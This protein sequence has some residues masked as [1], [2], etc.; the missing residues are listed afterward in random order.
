MKNSELY[1]VWEIPKEVEGYHHIVFGPEIADKLGWVYGL[2]KKGEPVP[3]G[4]TELFALSDK[5]KIQDHQDID[6][7]HYIFMKEA[8]QPLN[9]SQILEIRKEAG[10][11]YRSIGTAIAAIV[12]MISGLFSWAVSE[13]LSSVR[14]KEL[15]SLHSSNLKEQVDRYE[16]LLET[17]ENRFQ[18]VLETQQS[19][20]AE[21]LEDKNRSV[22]EA[23]KLFRSFEEQLIDQVVTANNLAA[24]ASSHAASAVKQ[25]DEATIKSAS[26]IK[27][28]ND[29]IE[30]VTATN[31][32]FFLTKSEAESLINKLELELK[33]AKLNSSDQN[34][35]LSNAEEFIKTSVSNAVTN[36]KIGVWKEVSSKIKKFTLECEYK[37]V[38]PS[39][40]YYP[41]AIEEHVLTFFIHN[42]FY[43]L[44]KDDTN[45]FKKYLN[46]FGRDEIERSLK[47]RTFERC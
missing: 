22:E 27:S 17:Q 47:V 32:E 20:Y 14:T 29:L 12:A 13:H 15:V 24:S 16:K 19:S 11:T 1:T 30:K 5:N 18:R 36:I 40:I 3:S 42:G 23:L 38:T 6:W 28:I 26:A 44:E 31:D 33:K 46:F 41:G 39:V 9:D 4:S 35:A 37:V 7:L 2:V 34:G 43:G 8:T 21:A 45:S 25:S 10:R